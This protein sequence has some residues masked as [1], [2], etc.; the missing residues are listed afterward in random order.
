MEQMACQ[1]KLSEKDINELA[2]ETKKMWWKKE[3]KKILIEKG[4]L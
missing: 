3:G 1:I 4:I 2:E